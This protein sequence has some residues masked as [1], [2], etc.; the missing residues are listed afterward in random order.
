MMV[1]SKSGG[2]H[3]YFDNK[4]SLFSH[5]LSTT[6]KSL[7]ENVDI[8]RR[9]IVGPT[10]DKKRLVLMF[11]DKLAPVPLSFFPL[12]KIQWNNIKKNRPQENI[13]AC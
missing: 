13:I 12:S 1:T 8:I 4:D 2:L 7:I 10:L 3:V 11:S 6:T 9:K 5:Q